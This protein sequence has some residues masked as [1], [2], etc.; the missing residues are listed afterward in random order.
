MLAPIFILQ[1]FLSLVAV[2]RI[3]PL[4]QKC[5]ALSVISTAAFAACLLIRRPRVKEREAETPQAPQSPLPPTEA[6]SPAPLTAMPDVAVLKEWKTVWEEA[7]A[8][9]DR[10]PKIDSFAESWKSFAESLER[11][12]SGSKAIMENSAKAFDISDN[13]SGTA[14]K[15]FSLSQQVQTRVAEL[16]AELGES[17][18]ET[19]RLFEESKKITGILEIISEI[20]AKTYVLSINASI[21]AT[22]AGIHGKAFDV[23]A[24]EVRQLAQETER[25][26][27]NIE[28]FVG[29]IQDIVQRVVDQTTT[30]SV[31]IDREKDSLLSVAGSLQGVILAV[32]IIRTVSGLSK[33]KA[34]EQQS[35]S[36]DIITKTREIASRISSESAD[37]RI[38]EAREKISRIKRILERY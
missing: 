2:W 7:D 11:L 12:Q 37:V 33:E 13:L 34:Q 32:E 21:V 1:L 9:L 38:E 6:S 14:E 27:K 19:R 16:T 25:S 28:E 3:S 24:K 22:R 10:I 17:L 8:L 36:R 5:I 31:K 18:E 20:S 4:A 35:I 29:H 26:L 23:V 15:A 30:T